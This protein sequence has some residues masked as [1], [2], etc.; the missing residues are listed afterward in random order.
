MYYGVIVRVLYCGVGG[1]AYFIVF[2]FPPLMKK[3]M[4]FSLVL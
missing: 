2:E 1:E 4:H 3:E